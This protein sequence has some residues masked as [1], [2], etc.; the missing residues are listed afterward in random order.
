MEC[1]GS[2]LVLVERYFAGTAHGITLYRKISIRFSA[3]LRPLVEHE[4]LR[5]NL[6]IKIWFKDSFKN[7]YS[8]ATR[9]SAMLQYPYFF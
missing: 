3:I 4:L 1:T 6:Q 9:F 2:K 8:N 7:C 5:I